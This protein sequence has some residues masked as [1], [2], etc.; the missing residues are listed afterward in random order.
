MIENFIQSGKKC[1]KQNEFLTENEIE[2]LNNVLVSF[3]DIKKMLSVYSKKVGGLNFKDE[4]VQKFSN[5]LIALSMNY[6]EINEVISRI[7]NSTDS[8]I[9]NSF[10]LECFPVDKFRSNED[11]KKHLDLL[12]NK[13]KIINSQYKAIPFFNEYEKFL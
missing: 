9:V 12:C 1:F 10:L 7:Q 5:S 3:D 4:N 13:L 11:C 6:Q 2:N 8:G